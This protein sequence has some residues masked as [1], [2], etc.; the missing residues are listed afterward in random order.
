MMVVGFVVA[1]FLG[2]ESWYGEAW[3]VPWHDEAVITRLAQNLATGKGFINDFL[4][5]VLTGAERR[6]YWQMPAYPMALAVWGKMFGFDLNA[7]RWFS[8]LLGAVILLLTFA[9]AVR[10]GA[11][12]FW[13]VVSVLW[14]A[15]DLNFQFAANFVRPE[16][17]C[18]VFLLL[19]AF[20]ALP[21]SSAVL[22]PLSLLPSR[23]WRVGIAV[24]FAVMTHPIAVPMALVAVISAYRRSGWQSAMIVVSPIS[25][26]MTAWF[27]YVATDWATFLAQWR[28]HWLH[29]ERTMV[30]LLLHCL[31]VTFWGLYGYLGVPMNAVPALAI[32]VTA[33]IATLR[34]HLSVSRVF[35]AFV[36]VLY[37]VTALGGEAF[38]PALCMPFIYVL[39]ALLLQGLSEQTIQPLSLVFHPP[40]LRR[41]VLMATVA[42]MWW[43]YQTNVVIRHCAAVPKIRRELATFSADLIQALPS[44]AHLLVG[45]FSPDPTFSLL[46][47]RPDVRIYALMP[48]PM[49]DKEAFQKA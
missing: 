47:F 10:L 36:A 15:S 7:L 48:L 2:V 32:V 17:L 16:M 6:T 14:V 25:I 21:S 39:A 27:F 11:S 38:Y 3:L 18:G 40:F 24:T 29:K 8:R 28:A 46:R 43:I 5:G 34:G 35:L 23:W 20:L 31:G 33:G 30:D 13:S 22:R 45:S 19:A 42:L 4:E 9:I 44:N 49:V 12:P 37:A 1:V 26:A 41:K